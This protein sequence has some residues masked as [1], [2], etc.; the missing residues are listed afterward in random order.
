[1]TELLY[2]FSLF[3]VNGPLQDFSSLLFQSRSERTT[4]LH[5]KMC[6]PERACIQAHLHTETVVIFISDDTRNCAFM[7]GWFLLDSDWAGRHPRP[8]HFCAG[9]YS[10]PLSPLSCSYAI[11][12]WTLKCGIDLQSL[13]NSI[14]L[15]LDYCYYPPGSLRLL[16]FSSSASP[17]LLGL[18]CLQVDECPVS[19]HV[20][21]QGL[22]F[23]GC[24]WMCQ[25]G[26]SV[27]R[28]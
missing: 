13:L 20:L 19:I 24:P 2:E 27:L 7:R 11:V 21:I 8:C 3:L 28:K 12:F 15:A 14:T 10:G 16:T 1:M 18:C 25:V 26:A 9:C 17:G 23:T 5:T 22:R 6:L 4:L